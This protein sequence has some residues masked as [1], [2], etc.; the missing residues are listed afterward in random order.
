[1]PMRDKKASFLSGDPFEDVLKGMISYSYSFR[2]ARTT[3]PAVASTSEGR[4]LAGLRRLAKSK[5][6]SVSRLHD[7]FDH[8]LSVAIDGEREKI[9]AIY[10]ARNPDRLRHAPLMN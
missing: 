4:S 2:N 9:A 8:T 7:V 5:F 10:V 6:V 3:V 1:M